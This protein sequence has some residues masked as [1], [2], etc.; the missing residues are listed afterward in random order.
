MLNDSTKQVS[1]HT[2]ALTGDIFLYCF[3]FAGFIFLIFPLIGFLYSNAGMRAPVPARICIALCSFCYTTYA[4][5]IIVFCGLVAGCER[6]T[7]L[8]FTRRSRI[9]FKCIVTLFE[10]GI[11]Y[12]LAIPFLVSTL[13]SPNIWRQ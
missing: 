8:F 13:F 5:P 12:F 4:F 3:L 7:G 9:L 2:Y 11:M 10:F 6:W 1:R